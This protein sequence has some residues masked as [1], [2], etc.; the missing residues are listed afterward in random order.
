ASGEDLALKGALRVA[1]KINRALK[2]GYSDIGAKVFGPAP[3]FISRL[4][5]KYRFKVMICAQNN[6]RMRELITRLLVDFKRDRQNRRISV[7]ADVNS[8]DF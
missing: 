8:M 4:N 3:A 7:V 1:G 5:N 2:T 6:R